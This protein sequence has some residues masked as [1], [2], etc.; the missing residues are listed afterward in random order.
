[1]AR[2]THRY[3]R[4]DRFVCGTVGRPGERAFFIQTRQDGQITSVRC[5]KEQLQVLTTHLG[6]ILDDLS[7]LAAGGVLV[8]DPVDEPVDDEPLDVPLEEEF[9]AGAI[10]IAWDN[11]AGRLVVEIFAVSDDEMMEADP[12]LLLAASPQDAPDSL[13]VH[14]TPTQARDFVAR[15][16][17][18]ISSGRPSCP[19]CGQPIS[20]QGHI[21]PRA[22]GY[23]RPLF[24]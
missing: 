5:D 7:R 15:G 10:A 17:L 19:F 2:L 22:N 11:A 18:V 24:L 9:T 8:P 20:G 1:M 12:Q 14:L 4:P 3:L 16:R 21:C 6:R 13:E 23:R